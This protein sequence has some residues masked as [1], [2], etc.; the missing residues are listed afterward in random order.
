[1]LKF[2]PPALREPA[3][4]LLTGSGEGARSGRGAL[5]AFSVRVASAVLAFL[6]QIFLA[7][8][9]GAFEFGIFSY[10]WIWIIV[11]GSLV[12]AGFA[13]SVVRFLPEYREREN[14]DLL[15]GFL[16]TGRTI[17][18]GVGA[19]V[20][21][22]AAFLVNGWAG[23]V[24]PVYLLPLSL[25]LISLP[26]YGLT[27]FQDGV[28]RAQGW[29]YLALIPPYIL[30]P[31][32]LFVFIGVFYALAHPPDAATA[33]L[34]L[35]IACWLTALLQYLAQRRRF[36]GTVPK[37]KPAYAI[38]F[39]IR[40]SLPLLMIDGFTL[41]IL[42]LDVLLLEFLRAPPD[43]IG[44]YFAALK[45]ISLIAFVHFSISAVAMPRFAALHARGETVEIGRFLARMQKWCFWPSLAG[46]LVLL[47]LGKP[48]LW[49][50]GPDFVAAYPVMFILA[51]GL[52][53]RAAAG[54]A[55]NLLAVSGHQDKA[56]MILFATLII[57]GGLGLTF[58]PRF[59]IQGAAMAT[60]AAFA[61][62][63][64]ATIVLTRRYFPAAPGR[65]ASWSKP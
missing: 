46:A 60:S 35:I 28:G 50:F 64:L 54:P 36:G 44:I 47:A 41:F 1:M 32:L 10:S 65:A 26:A 38:P 11:L 7:R 63:A 13:T 9:M 19:V 8:W 14:W 55:Q 52:L 57:N 39:W 40:T 49:L 48:L 6:T 31:I 24:E 43:R 59:G 42:N 22:L 5:A 23:I 16:R 27:D 21:I 12:S 30:R 25:A 56:A 53:A 2:V 51:I 34:A 4:T 3:E 20:A 29:I 37:T 33:A 61:F 62:E 58:I 15:R 45:T 17:A 18:F